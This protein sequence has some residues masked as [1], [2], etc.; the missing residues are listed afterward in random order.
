MKK[1]KFIYWLTVVLVLFFTRFYKLNEYPPHLTIDEVS[2]GYNAYSILKTGMDE[3]G[4]F[5]PA[6]FR[7]VGDYK[8]PTLIYLTVPFIKVFGLSEFAVRFPVALFSCLSVILFWIFTSQY[9]FKKN[10]YFIP[11]LSTFVYAISPWLIVYSRS[12]FEAVVAQTFM[13]ANIIFAFKFRQSKK[14]QDF[15]WMVLFA[16]ISAITY[17]STKLVVPLL[18]IIFIVCQ[19][20]LVFNSVTNWYKKE[21]LKLLILFLVLAIFTGFFIS[22]YIFGS[23]AARAKMTF[24]TKDFDFAAALLPVFQSHSLSWI[25][26]IVG[27]ILFWYKRFLEYFSSNFYLSTGLG[28]A[29]VGSPA[30]GV[31][32]AVEYFFLIIG[33]TGLLFK[34]QKIKDYFVDNF[35]I[36]FLISWL[37]VGILPASITNNA[38]H[39]LRTLNILP[40][41]SILISIGIIVVI[42]H[43][44]PKTLTFYF[45]SIIIFL[46]YIL[47]VVRFLDYYLLHYSVEL[48]ENR[49]FG[50]KQVS[51]YAKDHHQEY[52]NVYVDSR[53]G[54]EG[55]YSYGVPY[56]YLLFYSQY[57]PLTYI[58]GRKIFRGTNFENYIFTDI[59]WFGM[60]HNQNSLYISSPWGIPVKTIY[61]PNIKLYVPFLNNKS[62]LYV[63]SDK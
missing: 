61:N 48:S 62:G 34:L 57:D 1:Y 33:I 5:M 29:S 19:K 49:S 37:L 27:L 52:Q 38:Q 11:Y 56:L 3:W 4:E 21:K 23:G 32:Y 36:N 14:I 20:D 35:S 63:V 18:N 15:F 54:T 50:W 41:I 28:L 60:D 16:L 39:S 8:S 43:V 58:Q 2:I 42:N 40:T 51:I 46:G 6:S 7:S 17:H 24:L 22:N 12:S 31:I 30:Q 44:K 13:L 10:K 26:S 47:G 45:L 59:N 55:P 9:L 53:F 25:T